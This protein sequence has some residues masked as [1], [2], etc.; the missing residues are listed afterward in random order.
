MQKYLCFSSIFRR[1]TFK[2]K[3]PKKYE[4]NVVLFNLAIATSL[5][6][7]KLIHVWLDPDLLTN[8]PS[9]YPRKLLS[10]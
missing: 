9:G 1:F 10:V 6:A 3:L 4:Q 2:I 7:L 5:K 8:I